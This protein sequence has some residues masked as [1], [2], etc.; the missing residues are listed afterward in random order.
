MHIVSFGSRYTFR[1]GD[2]TE[3][4]SSHHLWQ[5]ASSLP[6]LEHAFS[7]AWYKL[8]TRDMGPISRCLGNNVPPPQD[9]QF[10]LPP[11][12]PPHKLADFTEVRA[13]VAKLIAVST[14]R[15]TLFTRLAW[16]VFWD[17]TGGR[18]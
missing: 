3:R 10:P 14:K 17:R 7:H 13:E 16:W 15:R 18:I 2:L 6:K 5:F 9:W 4:V 11:P 8:T 12:P 1:R